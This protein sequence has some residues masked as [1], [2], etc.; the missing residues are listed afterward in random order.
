MI[1]RRSVLKG[2]ALSLSGPM[3]NRGRFSLFAQSDT[4]YS[5]RTVELVRCSTVI[6]ILGLLTLD[7][8]KLSTW[9][10]DSGRFRQAIF[11]G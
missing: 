5:L 8:R 2:T 6:D 3:I 11:S 9:E 4:E 1:S 10:T 7:Y